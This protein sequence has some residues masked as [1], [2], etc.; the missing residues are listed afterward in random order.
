M[1]IGRFYLGPKTFVKNVSNKKCG[2]KRE[3]FYSWENE[4]KKIFIERIK[5]RFKL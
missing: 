1:E 2:M 4:E 5:K 3:V